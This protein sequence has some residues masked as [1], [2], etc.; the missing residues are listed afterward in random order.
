MKY[1]FVRVQV[2]CNNCKR[3]TGVILSSKT[4]LSDVR[5][6]YCNSDDIVFGGTFSRAGDL[7]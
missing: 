4:K 7:E 6:P 2:F 5:C 1:D 3:T